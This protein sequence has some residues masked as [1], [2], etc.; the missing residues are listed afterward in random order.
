VQ[1]EMRGQ[2]GVV[3]AVSELLRP[4]KTTQEEMP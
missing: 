3:G 4:H 1:G 2:T